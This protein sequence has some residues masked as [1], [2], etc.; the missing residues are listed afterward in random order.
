MF[1]MGP[2]YLTA[3][4]NLLG[5]VRRVTGSARVSF[6]ER[7][8]TSQPKAGTK[9]EVKV[10]THVAGI[11]DFA[12]GTMATLLTSFDVWH[13]ELPRIEIYGTEGSLSVPDPNTFGGP[14]RLRRAG[15]ETWTELPLT[16]GYRE[17]SRGL[18]VAD[19]AQA[20]AQ[21]RPH[22]ASGDLALHVLEIMHAFHAASTQ[23]RHQEIASSCNRPEALPVKDFLSI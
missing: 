5:P 10:P 14:V 7:L 4:V 13:A 18:G 16:H 21:G 22:R 3:L 19:M 6:K 15:A 8:I 23:G 11:M 17:N 9:I 1:D 20:L 2:Y 12:S